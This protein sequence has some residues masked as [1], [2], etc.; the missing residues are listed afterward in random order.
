MNLNK[1]NNFGLGNRKMPKCCVLKMRYKFLIFES[2]Y[3]NKS[4]EPFKYS[5]YNIIVF[6]A[7]ALYREQGV[8][9]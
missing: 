1:L 3:L 9:V 4:V 7:Q 2:N 6:C 8:L 5:Q